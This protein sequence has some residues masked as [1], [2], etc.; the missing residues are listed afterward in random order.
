M[1]VVMKT[2]DPKPTI[3]QTARTGLTA[4][5]AAV[6]I[7][8]LLFLIGSIF[9][10]P[11]DALTPLGEPVGLAPVIVVSAV[12]GI[13]ATVGYMVLLRFLTKTNANR[14]MWAFTVLVLIA[15]FRNPFGIEN[16]PMAEVVILEIMHF[17]AALPVFALTRS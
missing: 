5:V 8:A 16:V 2:E 17:V 13:A 6:V 1:T 11:D 14:V 4:A 3:A 10:F 15:M 9:T 12:G 7:N